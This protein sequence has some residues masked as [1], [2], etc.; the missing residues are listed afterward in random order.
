MLGLVAEHPLLTALRGHHRR[1][2]DETLRRERNAFAPTARHRG[3]WN[4]AIPARRLGA[5]LAVLP[6][7]IVTAGTASVLGC[8]RDRPLT[9]SFINAD[10]H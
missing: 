3:P 9:R 7:H 1:V 2:L 4:A 6:N 10:T 8:E 5:V